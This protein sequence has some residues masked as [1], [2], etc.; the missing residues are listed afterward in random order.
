MDNPDPGLAGP[1]GSAPAPAEP[2]APPAEA[3]DTNAFTA[4]RDDVAALAEDA[5]TYAQA[6]IAFQKTRAALAGKHGARAI[7]ALVLA[8]VLLHIALIALAVGAV[9]ALA[10]LVTIW[11]AI[12]IVVGVMLLGVALLVRMALGDGRLL[13]AL[14][15]PG[16]ET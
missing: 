15:A 3:E 12:A 6:E 1:S 4:L 13:G 5:R 16:D 10:P 11:G 8:V 2:P 14:F 9:I 7:A